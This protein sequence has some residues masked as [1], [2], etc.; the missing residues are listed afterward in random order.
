MKESQRILL[1]IYI[2]FTILILILDRIYPQ[3][4]TVQYTRYLLMVTLALSTAVVKK[5]YREQKIMS[6]SFLFLVIAD[7]FLV[8]STTIDSL[9]MDL[10]MFGI[11]GFMLAYIC[12]IAAYQKNFRIGKGEIISAIPV[13]AIFVLVYIDLL[14]YLNGIMVFMTIVFGAVLS[15]MT[16]SAVSTIFRKYFTKKTSLLLAVSGMLMYICDIGVAYS[17]FHPEYSTT[18]AAWLKNIVWAA[19]IPGWT[20]LSVVINEDN[21]IHN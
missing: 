15:Y 13:V 8:F 3:S 21:L 10:S 19:Y 5:K 6:L 20:L 7:F 12:L 16:W 2:P 18:Y 11:L 4:E 14:P 1:S 9:T 17:L